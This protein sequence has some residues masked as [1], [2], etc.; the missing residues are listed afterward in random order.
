MRKKQPKYDRTK[1][2][3]AMA[4][5]RVGAPPASRFLDEKAI[6]EKPKHKKKWLESEA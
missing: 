5:E 6:R 4:R 2:V 3:K 1:V